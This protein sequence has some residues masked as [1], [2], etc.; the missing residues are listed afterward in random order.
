MYEQN[1]FHKLQIFSLVRHGAGSRVSFALVFALSSRACEIVPDDRPPNELVTIISGHLLLR[2]PDQV[3][4]QH[5]SD[6]EAFLCHCIRLIP[7]LLQRVS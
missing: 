2:R 4:L 1:L 6:G 5:K 3:R 7:N